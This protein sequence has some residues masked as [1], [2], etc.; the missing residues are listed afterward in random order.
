M[1]SEYFFWVAAGKFFWSLSFFIF[2]VKVFSL[3]LPEKHFI[4]GYRQY[5]SYLFIIRYHI[6]LFRYSLRNDEDA[7]AT[8][9]I[10]FMPKYPS[11]PNDNNLQLECLRHLACLPAEKRAIIPTTRKNE[12]IQ[13]AQ[14]ALAFKSMCSYFRY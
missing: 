9:F 1:Q 5:I 13:N 7:V 11:H 12:I 14:I 10:A 4:I 6:C 8:I 3:C 2:M